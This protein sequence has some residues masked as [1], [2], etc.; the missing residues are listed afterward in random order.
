MK[1]IKNIF[2]TRWVYDFLVK[3]GLLKQ[4]KKSKFYILS[5]VYWK[6]D[7]KLREPKGKW[8]RSFRIN[9]QFRAFGRYEN[10]DLIIY[11]IDNHQK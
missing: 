6:T 10:G 2:E 9:K 3:R 4:Y 5:W 11:I 7:L 1:G 8:E